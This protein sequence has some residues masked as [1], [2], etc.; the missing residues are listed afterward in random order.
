MKELKTIKERSA[1]FASKAFESVRPDANGLGELM[2]NVVESA[3]Q[4]AYET[5]AQTVINEL[6]FIL[7]DYDRYDR[8]SCCLIRELIKKLKGEAE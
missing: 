1:E 6:E 4:E 8:M 2:L 7:K 5:G 3:I